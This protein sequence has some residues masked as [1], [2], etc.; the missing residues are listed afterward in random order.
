MKVMM[1]ESGSG[2][3]IHGTKKVS[4]KV[5]T[6]TSKRRFTGM[7]VITKRQSVTGSQ[8]PKLAHNPK[9]NN[10]NRTILPMGV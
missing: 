4:A 7:K 2:P 5:Q 6:V 9:P 3:W 10:A 8:P 1:M